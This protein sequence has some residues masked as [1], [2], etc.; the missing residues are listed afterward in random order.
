[1]TG[2]QGVIPLGTV[3]KNKC[4]TH[5]GT[6]NQPLSPLY[7][8]ARLTKRPTLSLNFKELSL[9]HW[10]NITSTMFELS[11]SRFDEKNKLCVYGRCGECSWET[12]SG[13]SDMTKIFLLGNKT[14]FGSVLSLM[15]LIIQAGMIFKQ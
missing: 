10:I 14:N 7:S 9:C 3:I 1:M 15:K 5:S 11:L 2:Q 13:T 8:N 12:G 4:Q 6:K